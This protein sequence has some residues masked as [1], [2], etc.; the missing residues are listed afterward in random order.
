MRLKNETASYF[1][2]FMK[3]LQALENLNTLLQNGELNTF[4]FW[5]Y[6]RS[7]W[8]KHKDEKRTK[9]LN[10]FIQC[11]AHLPRFEPA[12]RESSEYAHFVSNRDEI[13]IWL[14]SMAEKDDLTKSAYTILS[15]YP[16]EYFTRKG[17]N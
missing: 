13:I 10:T 6:F 12:N 5:S 17:S 9:V 11:L 1:D 4:S 3:T 14:F 8:T 15:Q 7:K 2:S 16:L